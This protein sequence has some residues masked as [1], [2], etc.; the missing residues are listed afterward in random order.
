MAGMSTGEGST[1]P[2]GRHSDNRGGRNW[3]RR[4]GIDRRASARLR[5]LEGEGVIVLIDRRAPGS[6]AGVARIAVSS[7][8]VFVIDAKHYKGL[9]H[10]RRSGPVSEL[11]PD[12]LH[13]GRR[14]CTPW[15]D[16]V[17]RHV[18]VV[19]DA[20]GGLAGGNRH[21]GARH[22]LPDAGGMGLRLAHR[23]P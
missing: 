1:G 12:E 2:D 20:A 9:V 19:R 16:L 13:V 4:A 5:L 17:A 21:P 7:A 22:V 11:G 3:G 14:D 8:G 10:T 23:D 6:P 18:E 15:V